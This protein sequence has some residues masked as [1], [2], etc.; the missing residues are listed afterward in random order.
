LKEKGVSFN[1]FLFWYTLLLQLLVVCSIAFNPELILLI[2]LLTWPIS[3]IW[4][5]LTQ[6]IAWPVPPSGTFLYFAGL[7]S[8]TITLLITSRRLIG[9]TT[10]P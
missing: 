5:L 4:F 1:Q 6:W 7:H 2:N 8:V 3:A 10:K 9:L